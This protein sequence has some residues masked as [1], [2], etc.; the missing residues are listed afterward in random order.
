MTKIV[1]TEQLSDGLR[2]L[3]DKIGE[4]VITFQSKYGNYTGLRI[5]TVTT[6]SI[7]HPCSPEKVIGIKCSITL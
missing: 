6:P 5:D 1:T 7:A 4:A 2:E 3:E